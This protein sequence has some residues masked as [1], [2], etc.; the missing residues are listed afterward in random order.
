MN[1]RL[2]DI[3]HDGTEIYVGECSA[4]DW[5]LANRSAYSRAE[6]RAIRAAWDQGKSWI[7]GGGAAAAFRVAPIMEG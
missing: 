5:L 3:E 4:A 1:V 7:D 2:Y 6:V